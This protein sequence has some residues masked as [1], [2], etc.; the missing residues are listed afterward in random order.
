MSDFISVLHEISLETV[1][2]LCRC[3]HTALLLSYV[4]DNGPP[5][6][7][8]LLLWNGWR[9]HLLRQTT[10]IILVEFFRVF[11]MN[12]CFLAVAQISLDVDVSDHL[13]LKAV[14]DRHGG[15]AAGSCILAS[16][17]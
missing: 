3:V 7:L 9:M 15:L 6:L 16:Q 2:I 5:V 14:A 17:L 13:L 11:I 12:N 8:R 10:L 4:I 1:F